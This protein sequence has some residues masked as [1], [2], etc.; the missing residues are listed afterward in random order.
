MIGMIELA[1][2]DGGSIAVV[3][4]EFAIEMGIGLAVGVAG[5]M[6]L[7]PVFRRVRLTSPALY[8]LRVLPEPASSTDSLRSLTGPGS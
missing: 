5:A 8:P 1:T 6:L 2:E 4:E 3:F 7:L